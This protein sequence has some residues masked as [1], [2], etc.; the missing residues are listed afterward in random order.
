MKTSYLKDIYLKHL[1]KSII[2]KYELITSVF[3]SNTNGQV[4]E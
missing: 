2:S 4:M 3:V 1:D